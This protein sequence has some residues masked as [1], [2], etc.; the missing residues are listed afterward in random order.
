VPRYTSLKAAEEEDS[1][2]DT[3]TDEEG[4]EE[5]SEDDSNNCDSVRNCL[6]K[7]L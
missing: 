7:I 4:D 6:Q 3:D 5:P 2:P 1:A